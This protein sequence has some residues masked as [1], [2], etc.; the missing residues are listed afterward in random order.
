MCNL[1]SF[2]ST[3]R[4]YNGTSPFDEDIGSAATPG[5]EGTAVIAFSVI[6]VGL[7]GV[8]V[9]IDVILYINWK[10]TGKSFLASEKARKS[11]LF[12]FCITVNGFIFVGT[13]FRGFQKM[14]HS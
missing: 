1:V 12:D 5:R 10:R 13:N 2:Y 11:T 14:T 9:I 4:V 7:T 8:F 3:G 6:L